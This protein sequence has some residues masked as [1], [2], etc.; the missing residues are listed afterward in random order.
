M[1]DVVERDLQ[2]WSPASGRRTALSA[3]G[4]LMALGGVALLIQ[5]DSLLAGVAAVRGRGRAGRRRDR[6]LPRAARAG[7]RRRGRLDGRGLRRASAGADAGAPR[8]PAVLRDRPGRRRCGRA[9]RRAGLPVVGLGE[10]RVLVHPA[11]RWSARSSWRPGWSCGSVDVDPAVVLTT[12]LVLVVLAGQRLPVAGAR[13]HRH[14]RR[15]AL[16][17]GRHHRRPRRDRPGPGRRRR[18]GRARDP[19]RH[20]GDG[21]PAA[22]P[23]RAARRSASAWPA[24]CS[25]ST[26][27]SS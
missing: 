16:H 12:T 19:G 10:G 3:A 22:G 8:R 5:H 23:G 27:A 9:G 26:R 20:L 4:L 15:P 18:A 6:A 2:P 25:P 7:G 11:G 14:Q 21:R 13:R 17:R 24:P 1:T